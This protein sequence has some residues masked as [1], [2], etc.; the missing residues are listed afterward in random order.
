VSVQHEYT[1]NVS[2][3]IN[4][5]SGGRGRQCLERELV[6]YLGKRSEAVAPVPLEAGE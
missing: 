1:A 6:G 2:T 3:F 5:I 4:M